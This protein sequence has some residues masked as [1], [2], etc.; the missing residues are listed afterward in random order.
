MYNNIWETDFKI[1]EYGEIVRENNTKKKSPKWIF[2]LILFF[3]G[4]AYMY[5]CLCE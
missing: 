4:I 5:I 1:N 3:I 2:V